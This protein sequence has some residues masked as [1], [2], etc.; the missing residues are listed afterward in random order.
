MQ[1]LSERDDLHLLTISESQR[2]NTKYKQAIYE[3]ADVVILCLPDDAAREAVSLSG[4]ARFIDAST[5][6]RTSPHWTYGLPELSFNRRQEIANSRLVSNPGCY[7]TGFL[8]AIRPLIDDGLLQPDTP[9]RIH[10]TSGYSGGGK[11]L[12][13]LYEQNDSPAWRIRPYSLQLTHKHV[14]EMQLFAKL[15]REPLFV[16]SV[17][18]FY[19]GMLIQVPLFKS[20]FTRDISTIEITNLLQKRY[21]NERFIR[22]YADSEALE[23][24]FLSP[25]HCNETNRLELM[26]FGNEEQVV[27]VARL[28]NLGKG[29]A[30]AAVQNLNLML[31]FPEGRGLTA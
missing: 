18:H 16:P 23:D 27:I 5:A 10:A 22:V 17:G 1:R 21:E 4:T 6:H 12:I 25:T 2:K 29:A 8:L 9:V 15:N 7:P 31:G 19:N 11:N 30:G 3:E 24:G 20:E 28:D 14:P 26:V 13:S